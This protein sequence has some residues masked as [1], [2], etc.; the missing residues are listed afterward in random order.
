LPWTLEEGRRGSQARGDYCQLAQAGLCEP[1]A[2]SAAADTQI[3]ECVDGDRE[4][5]AI[6]REAATRVEVRRAK[7]AADI[8][9]IL[10]AYV[11]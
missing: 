5:L 10:E 11:A 8:V 7:L 1:T 2:I 4:K 9:P 6:V 3:L